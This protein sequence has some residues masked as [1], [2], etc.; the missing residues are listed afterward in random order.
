MAI[1]VSNEIRALLDGRSGMPTCPR[2]AELS[3][4]FRKSADRDWRDLV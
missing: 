1:S 2:G 4:L 3:V